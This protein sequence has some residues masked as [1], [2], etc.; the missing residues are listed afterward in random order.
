MFFDTGGVSKQM[1][2]L[3]LTSLLIKMK[4]N[5]GKSSSTLVYLGIYKLIVYLTPLFEAII[6]F[7]RRYFELLTANFVW[8]N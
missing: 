4:E 2:E 5:Q 6:V 1:S 8:F 3:F 7:E